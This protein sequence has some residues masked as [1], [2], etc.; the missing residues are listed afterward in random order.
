VLYY[1]NTN[2]NSKVFR[3]YA[4]KRFNKGGF[5]IMMLFGSILTLGF[6]FVF[7]ALFI[8]RQQAIL[9]I[10]VEQFKDNL[11]KY[12]QKQKLNK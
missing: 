3:E 6:M 12:I 9:N 10:E 8:H 4:D 5:M 2:K 1:S 7:T 11:D